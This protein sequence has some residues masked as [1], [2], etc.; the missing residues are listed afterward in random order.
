MRIITWNANGL[1]K[2][3]LEF[4]NFLTSESIDVALI[5]ETHLTTN[6]AIQFRNYSMYRS[7]HPS[8]SSRGGAAVIIKNKIQHYEIPGWKTEEF[9]I[10]AINIQFNGIGINFGAVYSPPAPASLLRSDSILK[11]LIRLETAL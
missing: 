9:Q 7:D 5:S 1:V 4:E 11:C 2:R 6:T 8:G 10:A 3:K